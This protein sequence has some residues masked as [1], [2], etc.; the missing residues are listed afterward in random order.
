[1]LSSSYSPL[2]LTLFLRLDGNPRVQTDTNY[3]S[4][5]IS[6]D[7]SVPP[8]RASLT[9]PSQISSH[10]A[11]PAPASS[12]P[13][14]GAP[15]PS[16]GGSSRRGKGKGKA[17]APPPPAQDPGHNTAVGPHLPSAPPSAHSNTA[18]NASVSRKPSA[19]LLRAPRNP[20]S[21]RSSRKA[22]SSVSSGGSRPPHV[23]PS[24]SRPSTGYGYEDLG[25]GD[26]AWK[27]S[28]VTDGGAHE[29][30]RNY[31]FQTK[32]SLQL[33]QQQVEYERRAME[34]RLQ[35]LEREQMGI[36]HERTQRMAIAEQEQQSHERE[37]QHRMHLT[38]EHETMDQVASRVNIL[39]SSVSAQHN[40]LL[41]TT[42]MLAN[43]IGT[44]NEEFR[45]ISSRLVEAAINPLRIDIPE[46][47]NQTR[48]QLAPPSSVPP[49]FAL[50]DSQL[51][52]SQP[53]SG[54]GEPGPSNHHDRL[55][56]PGSPSG[57]MLGEGRFEYFGSDMGDNA[58]EMV[59]DDYV[60][61]EEED[62]D[63]LYAD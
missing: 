51:L 36:H 4:G 38:Q 54:S 13:S 42:N 32:R 59:E 11:Q 28:D 17:R 50:P 6:P 25:L 63:D 16:A 52:T 3:R 55:R 5:A 30:T 34:I 40:M 39:Q 44:D 37:R 19:S 48:G 14:L 29:Q 57:T 2:I 31:R 15:Q 61:E 23:A 35:M 41:S 49:S 62:E 43:T 53:Y 56:D 9:Q 1:M 24:I 33:R 8:S 12:A 21:A 60:A 27:H 18:S 7:P 26:D 20:T 47:M 58:M 45:R 10:A 46:M 22:L